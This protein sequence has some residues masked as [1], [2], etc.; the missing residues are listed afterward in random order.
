MTKAQLKKQ[1]QLKNQT[2]IT[3]LD[4]WQD[5]KRGLG[6]FKDK[7]TTAHIS[8]TNINNTI[9]DQ[10]YR[11]DD[12]AKKV[13]NDLV[14]DSLREGFNYVL[15]SKKLSEQF[16]RE[17]KKLSLRNH[18]EKSWKDARKYGGSV[19]LFG[20]DDG[21]TIDQPLNINRVRAIKWVIS[22]NRYQ[23][24]A[25]EIDTDITSKNFGKPLF[26][27]FNSTNNYTDGFKKVELFHAS[28]CIRFEGSDIGEDDF[29]RNSY[30]HGSVFES[31][32]TPLRDFNIAHEN[33]A[34]AFPE[35]WQGIYKIPTF[36]D[37]IATNNVELVQKRISA[38]DDMRSNFRAI[39]LGGDEEFD[40]KSLQ[41][42]GIPELLDRVTNRLVAA[43]GM[44]H[45]KLLGEG[46]QGNT[47]GRTE[48]SE[49][50]DIVSHKQEQYL[51]PI[52]E[53]IGEFFSY[54]LNKN[55]DEEI[56]IEFASL[57]QQD[58]LKE[59]QVRL[60]NAQADNLYINNQTLDPEEVAESRF[61]G[62]KYGEKIVLDQK[63][64][65][66]NREAANFERENIEQENESD[67]ENESEDLL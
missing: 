58:P 61:G 3:N 31:L 35:I 39:V 45:S 5:V 50:Y 33:V 54:Y 59:A 26:Y 53:Q 9:A 64:R 36:I 44:P 6:S 29:K 23:I 42:S 14:D 37:A 28:R 30:W 41:L 12:I 22:F 8:S 46:S 65:R 48:Q 38:M 67:L 15:K 7:R 62:L 47:S 51:Q 66:A 55:S 21:Q 49:W 16:N 25:E 19:L 13:V 57:Y 20:F 63:I 52:L 1:A 10:L 27:K 4:G 11:F 56:A 60:Q 34:A 32:Y 43:S 18:I 17:F 2:K 40:R 24:S